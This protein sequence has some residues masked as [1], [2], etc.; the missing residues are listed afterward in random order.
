[1]A[2]SGEVPVESDC[3]AVAPQSIMRERLGASRLRSLG[4]AAGA[5]LTR[6]ARSMRSAIAGATAESL[7]CCSGTTHKLKS[8]LMATIIW[9]RSTQFGDPH[10]IS[11]VEVDDLRIAEKQRTAS[12]PGTRFADVAGIYFINGAVG[13]DENRSIASHP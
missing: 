10:E 8:T 1:M 7:P 12:T 3:R 11:V 6:P 5:A 2:S 9:P 4:L 13:Q